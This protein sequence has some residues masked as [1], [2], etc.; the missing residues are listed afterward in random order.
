MVSWDAEDYCAYLRKT[1]IGSPAYEDNL[2]R[3]FPPLC[4]PDEVL[5]QSGP[6]RVVQGPA[7]FVDSKKRILS[8]ILPGVLSVR[9]QARHVL[10]S[11]TLSD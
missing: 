9:L 10:K 6:F 1:S 11:I 8:W 4:A 7:V 2:V 5:A 3:L